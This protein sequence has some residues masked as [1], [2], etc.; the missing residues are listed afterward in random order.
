MAQGLGSQ[1]VKIK[2]VPVYS[3][4]L[5]WCTYTGRVGILVLRKSWLLSLLVLI[6]LTGCA[7]KTPNSL[8][9][10][11]ARWTVAQ[12]QAIIK[13][14]ADVNAKEADGKTPLMY[15]VEANVSPDVI[16]LLIAA[17]ADVN[18]QEEQGLS[19]LSFAAANNLSPDI[20]KVLIE[21]GA[22][23][24]CKAANGWTPLMFAARYNSSPEVTE[25]LLKAGA[26]AN[27]PTL[28]LAVINN[29]PEVVAA[30][31][32]SGV[33]VNVKDLQGWSQLMAAAVHGKYPE[34]IHILL[35]AGADGKALSPDGKTAFEHA[36]DNEHIRGTPAYQALAEAAGVSLDQ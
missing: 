15:T 19:P 11:N 18:A 21:A 14:G 10:F 9:P 16:N 25:M 30:L 29:V 28:M 6:V 5:E 3:P 17:G 33:D 34:V 7:K 32:D 36:T 35:E 24:N 23:V 13:A 27:P 22:D 20:I 31:V 26:D 4:R 1:K 8:L 12:V 2:C